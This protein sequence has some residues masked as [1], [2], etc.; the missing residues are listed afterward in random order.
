MENINNNQGEDNVLDRVFGG[1]PEVSEEA[2][3]NYCRNKNP[4]VASARSFSARNNATANAD[5]ATDT[6][7]N[8]LIDDY[9]DDL[10]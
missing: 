6:D 7:I 3:D 4:Y 5:T 1:E 2:L 10:V 8:P 9:L